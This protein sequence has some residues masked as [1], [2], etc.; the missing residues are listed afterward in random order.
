MFAFRWWVLLHILL[1]SWFIQQ[2]SKASAYPNCPFKHSVSDQLDALRQTCLKRKDQLQ[3]ELFLSKCVFSD[4]LSLFARL[5]KWLHETFC[6]ALVASGRSNMPWIRKGFVSQGLSRFFFWSPGSGF[7]LALFCISVFLALALDATAVDGDVWG[8]DGSAVSHFS[9]VF[10]PPFV[11]LWMT[12]RMATIPEISGDEVWGCYRGRIRCV[13][14]WCYN[15][16][17]GSCIYNWPRCSHDPWWFLENDF[18]HC[19][20]LPK[21]KASNHVVNCQLLVLCGLESIFFEESCIV[22]LEVWSVFSGL[23]EGLPRSR[24]FCLGWGRD[25]VLASR[26]GPQKTVTWC[27]SWYARCTLS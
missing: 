16:S 15:C 4:V 21:C 23:L 19:L 11:L 8:P 22:L 18:Q 7:L 27:R 25:H 20:E 14:I 12:L 26:R 9:G 17:V 1:W 2:T 6:L 24:C 13:K 3:I 5:A 10:F